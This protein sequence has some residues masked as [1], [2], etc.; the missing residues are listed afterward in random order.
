MA[1]TEKCPEKKPSLQE[2]EAHLSPAYEAYRGWV[3]RYLALHQLIGNYGHWVV[4]L[5][6]F[7][8]AT[9]GFVLAY[10]EQWINP[11]HKRYCCYPQGG[12][13]RLRSARAPTR[14]GHP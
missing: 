10:N 13:A 1:R 11:N 14:C 9:T 4:T 3:S 6:L 7:L 2:K 5:V 12:G 8:G